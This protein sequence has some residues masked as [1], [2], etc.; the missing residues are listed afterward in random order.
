M[1]TK[2]FISVKIKYKYIINRTLLQKRMRAS[3]TVFA[4]MFLLRLPSDE[5]LSIAYNTLSAQWYN[6][7]GKNF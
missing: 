1:E 4:T 5:L 7:Y 3:K 2:W 6:Y